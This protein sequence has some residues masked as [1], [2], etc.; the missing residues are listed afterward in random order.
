MNP[1]K[2][3]GGSAKLQRHLTPMGHP[4]LGAGKGRAHLGMPRAFLAAGAVSGKK[5]S[6]LCDNDE[7]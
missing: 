6:E 4:W 5:E 3:S 1:L 2:V 7:I